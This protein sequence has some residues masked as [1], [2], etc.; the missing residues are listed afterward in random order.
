MSKTRSKQYIEEKWGDC[1][2]VFKNIENQDTE[3]TLGHGA[4][5]KMTIGKSSLKKGMPTYA[6]NGKELKHTSA[7]QQGGCK[8][9]I[10]T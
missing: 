3:R 6:K 2:N 4:N 9:K 8:Q 5:G 10:K 7:S 1:S